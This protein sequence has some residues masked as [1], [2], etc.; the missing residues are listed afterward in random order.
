MDVQP[1]EFQPSTRQLSALPSP[2]EL[3]RLCQ[4]LAVL[5]AVLCEEWEGRCYS[6]NGQWGT[7]EQ[8][9]TMR[10]GSGDEWQALFTNAGVILFGLAHESKSYRSGDPYPE[11]LQGL[12]LE[13][14]AALDEPAFDS[15]NLSFCLWHEPGSEWKTGPIESLG[16]DGSSE[17]LELLDGQPRSYHRYAS[18]Y[19]EVE[20]P[21]E[22]IEH[23]YMHHPL[24]ASL[25][26][27]LSGERDLGE[28][29][30]DLEEIGYLQ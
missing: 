22:G 28:L 26:E 18:E 23:V 29:R 30:E 17:L 20:L 6:F 19:F 8:L 7:D 4:S 10:N 21:L 25:L 12:P 15:Q 2:P 24:T 14:K 3:R 27:S 13:L 1:S 11:I 9:A 16:E 5:D